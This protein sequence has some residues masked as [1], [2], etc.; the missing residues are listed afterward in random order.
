MRK[1]SK[2]KLFVKLSELSTRND[3]FAHFANV[4]NKDQR[5]EHPSVGNETYGKTS[6]IYLYFPTEDAKRVAARKLLTAGFDTCNGW[7][8]SNKRGIEVVV[9]YFKGDRWWE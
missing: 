6:C 4:N 7:T 2:K 3:A 5:L 9:T 8:R 1:Q